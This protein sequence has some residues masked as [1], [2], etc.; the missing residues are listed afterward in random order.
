MLATLMLPRH[1]CCRAGGA[2]RV[3]LLGVRR[4]HAGRGS[5]AAGT[6]TRY[7][8]R[9]RD[10]QREPP[11]HARGRRARGPHGAG[12][13][14]RPRARSSPALCT[15][16]AFVE[17]PGRGSQAPR[18]RVAD[19][20]EGGGGQHLV[21]DAEVV[22]GAVVR[23]AGARALGLAAS[24]ADAIAN[25]SIDTSPAGSF[26]RYPTIRLNQINWYA[27]MYA[28]DATVDRR[29][30]LLRHDTA[31][32]APALR[33]GVRGRRRPRRRQ[34]RRRLRFHYLPELAAR[35]TRSTSTRAEYANIVLRVPALLRAG[36]RAPGWRAL[37]R[38]AAA[39]AARVDRAR[40]R[41]A[42][43]RTPAT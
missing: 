29:P 13:A 34:P 15:G 3:R 35:R 39:L 6:A 18:A 20:L 23:L 28:A 27:L 32:P 12:P 24:T 1:L 30:T 14:R 25:R 8:A 31:Q 40:D 43:G 7:H 4:S 41:A 33:R 11:A 42:T 10:D 26:W 9:A 5:I 17:T 38:R 37:P 21:F 16:P 36:A 19:G 2:G 22:D